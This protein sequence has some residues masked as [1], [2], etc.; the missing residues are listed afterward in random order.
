MYFG[1]YAANKVSGP[2]DKIDAEHA[3]PFGSALS[4]AAFLTGAERNSDFLLSNSYAPLF[5]LV[6]GTHWTHNMID[7]NPGH[8]CLTANYMVQKLFGNFQ[9]ENYIGFEG[10]LPENVYLSVEADDKRIIIKLVNA[11]ADDLPVAFDL[12][13]GD[14]KAA[15][16]CR[17]HHDDLAARNELPFEGAAVYHVQ[18]EEKEIDLNS[19]VCPGN[20]LDVIVISR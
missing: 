20:T 6:G 7:F 5:N 19:Y 14:S 11:N 13:E 9:A 8:V 3:N 18:I 12:T 2:D 16:V 17:L 4:E 15:K 1:E 10:D